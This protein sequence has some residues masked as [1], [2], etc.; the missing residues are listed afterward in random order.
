MG[1]RVRAKKQPVSASQDLVRIAAGASAHRRQER[2][3]VAFPDGR[4]TIAELLIACQHD[5]GFQVSQPWKLARI[6]VENGPQARA[7]RHF[8]LIFR[9]ADD[10]LQHAE[11][12][13]LDAHDC[14]SNRRSGAA[15][16]S[17]NRLA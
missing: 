16:V 3:F 6:A 10:I 17:G 9:A 8:D 15:L 13:H 5:A 14:H 1:S 2:D 12:Q 11:K 4:R 7:V